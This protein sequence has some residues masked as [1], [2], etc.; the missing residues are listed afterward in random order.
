MFGGGFTPRTGLRLGFG[1]S[2]GDYAM[3]GSFVSRKL[4]FGPEYDR[5]AGI[6][7]VWAHR[8]W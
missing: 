8:W 1:M 2:T 5:Q 7:L 3:R 4:S 6:S